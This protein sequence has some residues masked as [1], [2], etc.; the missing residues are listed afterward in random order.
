MYLFTLSSTCAGLLCQKS[1]RF[2]IFLKLVE[3]LSFILDS[4]ERYEA[5]VDF[6]MFFGY[7]HVSKVF[8]LHSVAI[9]C[10]DPHD[11]TS[12]KLLPCSKFSILIELS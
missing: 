2:M 6:Q 8:H 12:L 9:R 5:L 10:C 3:M 1:A 7:R 4:I 11:H